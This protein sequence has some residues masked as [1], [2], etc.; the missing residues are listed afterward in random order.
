MTALPASWINCQVFVA[1]LHNPG[2]GKGGQTV[3]GRVQYHSCS[4][5]GYLKRPAACRARS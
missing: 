5:D 1:F 2:K 4:K 3:E